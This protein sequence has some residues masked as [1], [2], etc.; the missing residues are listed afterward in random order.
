MSSNEHHEVNKNSSAAELHPRSHG[1]VVS[2]GTPVLK[3]AAPRSAILQ[4]S[5][6]HSIDTAS[7]KSID[8]RVLVRPSLIAQKRASVPFLYSDGSYTEW[9]VKKG[10]ELPPF[11]I[12][13]TNII[14]F[15]PKVVAKNLSESFRRKSIHA[16]YFHDKAEAVC[17]TSCGTKFKVILYAHEDPDKTI[18]EVMKRRGCSLTFMKIRM[19]IAKAAVADYSE[20]KAGPNTLKVPDFIAAL[21]KPP[22]DEELQANLEQA[23]EELEQSDPYR[24]Q[25]TLQL[26]AA[27]T[28]ASK[29]HAETSLRVANMILI[30]GEAGIRELCLNLLSSET[31][32]SSAIAIK[33]AVLTIFRNS[34]SVLSNNGK[35]KDLDED[36]WCEEDLFPLII[37]EITNS[38]CPHGCCLLTEC[39]DILLKSS[40]SLREKALSSGVKDI[41][42]KAL[43]CGD[44]TYLGL[45]DNALSA[46]KTLE[47]Q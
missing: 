12:G 24:Q 25:T 10:Q 23:V 37:K 38:P 3:R 44:K 27:M 18:M 17:D 31:C 43:N 6:R 11:P 5:L 15:S 9:S 7:M 21:Y 14:D 29:S 8:P 34:L 42:D 33:R 41:L 46:L 40:T 39:I 45:Y 28:D 20:E 47:C 26:L 16:I 35:E 4:S 13:K 1:A 19:A 22:T 30:D 32:D 2:E 36:G